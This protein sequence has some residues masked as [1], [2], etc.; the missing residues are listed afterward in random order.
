MD[1]LIPILAAVG[2]LVVGL[3][4]GAGAA[5]TVLSAWRKDD[6]DLTDRPIERWRPQLE[7]KQP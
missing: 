4:L 7:E 1:W 5:F 2:A 6:D 3:V